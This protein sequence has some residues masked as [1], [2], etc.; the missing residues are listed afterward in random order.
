M[1]VELSEVSKAVAE[2]DRVGAGLVVLR[3]QYAAVVY[4]VTTPKGMADAR[5][6][7]AAIR[8]PRYEIE[9]IRKAAKAPILALGKQL[10]KEAE[11]ITQE[12]LKLEEPVDSAIKNEEDRKEQER[13]AK[14]AAEQ[15]RVADIQGRVVELGGAVQMARRHNLT[16]A[17]LGEHIADLEKIP[18]DDS[19]AEFRTA[20]ETTKAE[21]LATLREM[22]AAAAE[23]EAEAVRLKA[24]REELARLRAEDQTRQAAER[25][26]IAEEEKAAK[27]IRDA[28]AARQA[29]ALRKQREVQDA[30]NARVRSEQEAEAKRLADGRAELAAAQEALRRAQEPKPEPASPVTRHAQPLPVPSAADLVSVLQKYYRASPDTIIEWLRAIDWKQAEAA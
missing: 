1:S 4:D 10:D 9:R 22:Q 26:R 15:K 12:L 17:Q 20:A 25:A 23:R 2:F 5:A 27:A 7:R 14:I 28:E 29:E 30:E 21:T 11:R 24:E 6:A 16:A 13:Q 18:V 19:F 8:E 3:Q